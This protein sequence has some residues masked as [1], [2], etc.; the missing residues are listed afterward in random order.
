MS[1]KVRDGG[2][3]RSKVSRYAAVAFA[4]RVSA[5]WHPR[6]G[7]PTLLIYVTNHCDWR[8]ADRFA[9]M[10]FSTITTKSTRHLYPPANPADAPAINAIANRDFSE[11][12]Q[13][14]G[15]NL[16]D[17]PCM[18]L[19][20][21]TVKPLQRQFRRSIDHQTGSEFDQERFG[22]WDSFLVIRQNEDLGAG[23]LA[24]EIAFDGSDSG[25][26]ML[27]EDYPVKDPLSPKS[28]SSHA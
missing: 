22:R 5:A 24:T 21:G 12:P 23:A 1:L 9:E 13:K 19:L 17:D 27:I 14:L 26:A 8:L 10:R 7:C 16:H 20:G 2:R 6:C 11:E 25:I 18:A 28:K 4:A 15:L 3:R